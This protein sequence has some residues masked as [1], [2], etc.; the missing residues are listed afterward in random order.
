MTDM[1]IRRYFG[2]HT[3]EDGKSLYKMMDESGNAAGTVIEEIWA[4]TP[5]TLVPASHYQRNW[6]SIT[7]LSVLLPWKYPDFHFRYLQIHEAFLHE[8]KNSRQAITEVRYIVL[9]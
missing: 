5:V 3:S 8:N 7:Q 4:D 9:R 6:L 1:E 2:V